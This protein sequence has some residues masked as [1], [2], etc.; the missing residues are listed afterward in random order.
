MNDQTTL[1]EAASPTSSTDGGKG[2]GAETGSAI[3]SDFY[4]GIEWLACWLLDNAEGETI[5]EEQLRPWAFQAWNAHLG[6][7]PECTGHPDT[8]CRERG[9]CITEYCPACEA[10]YH[11]RQSAGKAKPDLS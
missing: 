6:S 4:N 1:S 8:L 11:R 10:D 2:L 9:L 7:R 5:T 3:G